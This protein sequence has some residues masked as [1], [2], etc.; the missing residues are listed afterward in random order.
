MQNNLN[1]PLPKGLDVPDPFI[2]RINCP[3]TTCLS[4]TT[5]KSQQSQLMHFFHK[6][7]Q[8]SK[9]PACNSSTI[10]NTAS[11]STISS[12]LQKEIHKKAVSKQNA[13]FQPKN[14]EEDVFYRL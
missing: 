7:C 2:E 9:C 5:F 10:K 8:I 11:S 3:F 6:H 1:Y 12:H 14:F 4:S 13:D